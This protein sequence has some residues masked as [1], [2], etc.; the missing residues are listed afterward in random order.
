VNEE[1]WVRDSPWSLPAL[2][3][4]GKLVVLNHIH[5][6]ETECPLF[7]IRALRVGRHLSPDDQRLAWAQGCLVDALARLDALIGSHPQKDKHWASI[8]V[9]AL[10]FEIGPNH[11]PFRKVGGIVQRDDIYAAVLQHGEP[12]TGDKGA[13]ATVAGARGLTA[14][15]VKRVYYDAKKRIGASFQN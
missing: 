7:W 8:I 3:I 11:N 5:F 13:F 2:H 9:E 14:H 15:K 10:G 1:D 12:L 4:A 6:I